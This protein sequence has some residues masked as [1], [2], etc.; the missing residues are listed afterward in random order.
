[1]EVHAL[2]TKPASPVERD[3]QM[4]GVG[5]DTCRIPQH[6]AIIM[7]GNR[8]WARQRNQPDLIGHCKGAATLMEIVETA[9]QLGVRT[10]TVYAFSTE[11][12]ARSDQEVQAIFDLIGQQLRQQSL[13]LQRAGVS[14][15]VIGDRN[16]LPTS[17]DE[18]L[19]EAIALTALGDRL[20]LVLA[21]NYGGRD[22]ICRALRRV[23]RDCQSGKIQA[24]AV[25]ETLITSYLDTRDWSDPDLC[26]RTSG[27][28]RISNFLLWQLSYTEM[29]FTD[30]LWPDFTGIDFV[31]AVREY[32]A[33]CRRLGAR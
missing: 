25:D 30:T 33:R 7:D 5:L 6:V 26:I 21:I 28:R 13:Q 17:L 9:R 18:Q 20:D 27:E 32:Q 4:P 8:R 3:E 22:D 23:V 2:E 16:R 12:W 29:I 1:M 19:D 11:N 14:L 31:Q 15:K 24:S 10:L